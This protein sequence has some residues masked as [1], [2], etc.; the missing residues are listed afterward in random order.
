MGPDAG[1]IVRI[2]DCSL[3]R[4][5]N[6]LALTPE[7]SETPASQ[8]SECILCVYLVQ[9][10]KLSNRLGWSKAHRPNGPVCLSAKVCNR[11]IVNI[12]RIPTREDAA[13]EELPSWYGNHLVYITCRCRKNRLVLIVS[14]KINSQIKH[15]SYLPQSVVRQHCQQDSFHEHANP[16]LPCCHLSS[17]IE[18]IVLAQQMRLRQARD[19]CRHPTVART[20]ASLSRQRLL[21]KVGC[22]EGY[23]HRA[24]LQRRCMELQTPYK[25]TR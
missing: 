14:C 1:H 9:K 15:G 2:M 16:L 18:L 13:A 22:L 5:F 7:E 12:P 21:V 8:K 17:S 25:L 10:W 4:R 6:T 20:L 24:L 11:K 23:T 3:Q 19:P